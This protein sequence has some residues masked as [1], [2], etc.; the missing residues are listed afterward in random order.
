MVSLVMRNGII[1]T[2]PMS[3]KIN[4]AILEM[5]L[6]VIQV[7]NAAT[8][9]WVP[10]LCVERKSSYICNSENYIYARGYTSK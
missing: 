5:K 4:K 1:F 9:P 7:S 6:F 2:N 3:K 8:L 10:L